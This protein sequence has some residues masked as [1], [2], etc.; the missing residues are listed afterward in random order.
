[1]TN[2]LKNLFTRNKQI[3]HTRLSGISSNY[4]AER[5]IVIFNTPFEVLLKQQDYEAMNVLMRAVGGRF[6]I[7]GEHR[8]VM[9][10]GIRGGK[11]REL[12]LGV[13]SY[14]GYRGNLSAL[15]K[16][17]G[18]LDGLEELSLRGHKLTTLPKEIGKLT[19]LKYLNISQNDMVNLPEEILNILGLSMLVCSG[20]KFSEM[21]QTTL[22][23]LIKQC[24][25]E[26]NPGLGDPIP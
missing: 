18:Y 21:T 3:E 22:R 8:G 19:L 23:Q 10:Y 5:G 6:H 2:I 17:I 12:D 9:P 4:D 7:R 13:D 26:V 16:E 11:I 25:P 24:G 1:M 20:N 15:P 14:E